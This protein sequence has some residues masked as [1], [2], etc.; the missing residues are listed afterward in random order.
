[1]KKNRNITAVIMTEN[2]TD[3]GVITMT[4][5]NKKTIKTRIIAALL[6][7]IASCSVITGSVTASVCAAATTQAQTQDGQQNMS[8]IEKDLRRLKDGGLDASVKLLEENVPGG[9]LLTPFIKEIIGDLYEKKEESASL[10][11]LSN[12]INKIYDQIKAF[13]DNMKQELSHVIDTKVFSYTAFHPLNSVIAG[14]NNDLRAIKNGNYTEM[15]KLGKIA[16]LVGSNSDW[17][18]D[19]HAFVKFTTVTNELNNANFLGKETMFQTIYNYFKTRCMLSGEAYDLAK[20]IAD[21]IMKNY[22]A[23]YAV[24]MESLTAQLRLADMKDKS[25]VDAEDL[26]NVCSDKQMILTR[27]NYLNNQVFGSVKGTG[28]EAKLDNSNTVGKKYEDVFNK[29]TFDRLVIINKGADEHKLAKAVSFDHHQIKANTAG[30]ARN[31]FNYWVNEV[32]KPMSGDT[33]RALAAYAAS[34]NMT[35]R[36]FLTGYGFDLNH[37]PKNARLVTCTATADDE[38][39]VKNI[40]SAF[41]GRVYC[42]ANYKGIDIDAKNA[43]EKEYRLWNSGGN[44]WTGNINEKFDNHPT[45]GI[46][47]CF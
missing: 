10:D 18:K 2:T 21:K 32:G 6:S 26:R 7:A 3:K 40:F 9:A 37:V 23:A 27:I 1:M 39:S 28:K 42:H 46:A 44:V 24:V 45:P 5:C 25:G 13:E 29:K 47:T 8:R 20:P 14:M 22:M 38:I 19:N 15:Q 43:G 11:S 17:N 41:T 12:D 35:I 33:V 4:R 30:Q 34:K 31:I 16:A 36:E